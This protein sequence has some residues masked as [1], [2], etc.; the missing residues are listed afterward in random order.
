MQV[1]VYATVLAVI[2][3]GMAWVARTPSQVPTGRVAA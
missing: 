3:S 2:A 1:I